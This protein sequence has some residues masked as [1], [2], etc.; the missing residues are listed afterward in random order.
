MAAETG[1]QGRVRE[2]RVQQVAGGHQLEQAVAV[3]GGGVRQTREGTERQTETG[4]RGGTGEE[5]ETGPD[6]RDEPAVR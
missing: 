4:G 1:G 6:H 2:G 5:P 3:Q